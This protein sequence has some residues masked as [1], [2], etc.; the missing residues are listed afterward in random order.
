[1]SIRASRPTPRTIA[2]LSMLACAAACGSRISGDPNNRE[3]AW[4]YGPV[5]GGATKVHVQGAGK[6]K[7]PPV[8]KGWHCR[9]LERKRLTVQPYQL[10]DS[11]PLFGKVALSIALFDKAGQQLEMVRTDTLTAQ[12][13]VMTFDIAESVATQLWDVTIWYVAV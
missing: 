6:D 12:T 3:I 10:A 2:L 11:H 4:S 7:L 13:S 5:T 1:M 8:A 9:L